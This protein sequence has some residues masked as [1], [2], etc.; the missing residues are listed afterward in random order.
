MARLDTTRL[1]PGIWF[2]RSGKGNGL[3][4][5][6]AEGR[7]VVRLFLL[8]MLVSAAVG[9]ALAFAA[10]DPWWVALA[11]LGMVAS[12]IWFVITSQRHGDRSINYTDILI[13]E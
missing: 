13:R 12:A 1:R 3:M 9:G 4:P 5:V 10:R 2:V 7:R 6:T 11:G 8:C